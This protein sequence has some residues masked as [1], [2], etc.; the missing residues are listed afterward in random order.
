MNHSKYLFNLFQNDLR[1]SEFLVKIVKNHQSSFNAGYRKLGA[2]ALGWYGEG[3][4]GGSG[5]G[6]RVYLW[7][8]HVDVW[9]NQYDI[10]K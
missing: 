5:L 2:G 1:V 8:M 6:T 9:Q 3:D 7:Q 4:G 10:V